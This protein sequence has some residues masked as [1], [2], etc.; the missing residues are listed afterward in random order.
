MSFYMFVC[1]SSVPSIPILT[2]STRLASLVVLVL[3]DSPPVSQ[4]QAVSMFW[5]ELALVLVA[6]WGFLLGPPLAIVTP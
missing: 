1:L 6:G 3:F 2:K 4:V 5:T